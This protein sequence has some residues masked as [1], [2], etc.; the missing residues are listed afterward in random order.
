MNEYY[1]VPQKMTDKWVKTHIPLIYHTLYRHAGSALLREDE[2]QLEREVGRQVLAD[3]VKE[4]DIQNGE[5]WRVLSKGVMWSE[6]LFTK[7]TQGLVRRME[8]MDGWGRDM[9]KRQ[10]R[11]KRGDGSPNQDGG[12]RDRENRFN[13]CL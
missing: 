8:W 7:V 2:L 12:R 5:L 10:L 13:R 1:N 9:V 11:S 3:F 6:R 4:F